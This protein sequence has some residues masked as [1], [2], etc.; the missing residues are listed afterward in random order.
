MRI[1]ATLRFFNHQTQKSKSLVTYSVG[2]PVEK[3]ALTHTAAG[4]VNW[5]KC[6][7]RQK[8][9]VPKM[10]VSFII[11]RIYVRSHGKGEIKVADRIIH[12]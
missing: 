6:C 2:K 5:C 3:Q 1:T 11:P 12:H 8:N 7:G 4:R 10:S 9:G